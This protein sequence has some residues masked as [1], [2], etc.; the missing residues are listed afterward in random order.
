[1]SGGWGTLGVLWSMFPYV[2]FLTD[3]D[4]YLGAFISPNERGSISLFI[5]QPKGFGEIM[6]LMIYIEQSPKTLIICCMYGDYYPVFQ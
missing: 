5:K 3:L 4:I 1:M 2:I 6:M